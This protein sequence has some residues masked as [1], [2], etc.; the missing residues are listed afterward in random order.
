MAGEVSSDSGC[1]FA[2]G[3]GCALAT[4]YFPNQ[5]YRAGYCPG[6]ALQKGT[7]FPELV[8]ERVMPEEV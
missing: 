7:L 5:S 8:F 2:P 6:E 3:G 1:G 4:V